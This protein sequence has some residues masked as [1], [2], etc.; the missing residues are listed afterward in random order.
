MTPV[1]RFHAIGSPE[2]LRIEDVDLP[3]PGADE[4]Y[5]TAYGRGGPALGSRRWC[6]RRE[7][8]RVGRMPHK[9]LVPA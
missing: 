7:P 2:V 4:V 8:R 5:I 1:V 9:V 3:P 6:R